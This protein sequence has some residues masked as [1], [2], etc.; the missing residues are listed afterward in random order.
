[1]P[2]RKK[3]NDITV[4]KLINEYSQGVAAA[5]LAKTYGCTTHTI[6][7]TLRRAEINTR[8]SL[9][10][11][12][13][14]TIEERMKMTEAAH[15]AKRGKPVKMS[16]KIKKAITI[17]RLGKMEILE[18]R[19]LNK[20]LIV[21]PEIKYIP[22]KAV[23]PYN[24]DIALTESRIAV[25]VFGGNWHSTGRHADRFQKRV[26]FILDTGWTPVIVWATTQYPIDM[27][28]A[29]YIIS[30][31][32]RLSGQEPTWSEKHVIWGTGEVIPI[33]ELDPITGARKVRFH[34]HN[35]SRGYD[36]RFR[37]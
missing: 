7:N 15:T 30:L 3:F 13:I 31:H 22:Q 29:N 35:C 33:G 34:G 21:L 4:Q 12:A 25:E 23:G 36:G 18:Q 10:A 14:M 9:Q 5:T 27:G 17:E 16:T 20:I 19:L 11:H 8:N 6:I 37:K 24:V 26:E 1:M 32:Q 28:S 2:Q